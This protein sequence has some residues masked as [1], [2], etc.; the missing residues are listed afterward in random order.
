LY[1]YTVYTALANQRR[2]PRTTLNHNISHTVMI[3]IAQG[4]ILPVV[5]TLQVWMRIHPPQTLLKTDGNFGVKT[6][7]AVAGFQKH[8]NLVGDGIV[9]RRTW[10]KLMQTTNAQTIDVVDGTD[11]SLVALEASDIRSAG[12]D[13]IVVYGMSNGVQYIMGQILARARHGR[14][15]LLRFHGHG[16]RGM[17]NVTGGEI[18]GAP[19]LAGIS[20]DNFSQIAGT[21]A[22]ISGIFLPY[23]SVQML[24]CNVGGG[25][26][27]RSLM[28]KLANVWRV[29]CTAGV[30]TQY[31][32]GSRTFRFEGP[33]VSGF[34]G[35]GDLASWG[36][37][38]G[39]QFGNVSV[40]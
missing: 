19:H 24:G 12:G 28:D 7:R 39:S 38:M 6:H 27:G 34:P 14:V 5:G 9:G 26:A 32:G 30:N 20:N 17:Q 4:T 22:G 36:A 13:P 40:A 10:D 8:N 16:N 1:Q 23:G 2:V 29:P 33:T 3:H 35:G 11:P 21:L 25:S 15:A 31:G 18:Y 37:R